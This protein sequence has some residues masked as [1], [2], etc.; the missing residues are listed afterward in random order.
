MPTNGLP[1]LNL[2]KTPPTP[3][4]PS[5]W[6]RFFCVFGQHEE[7]IHVETTWER[8]DDWKNVIAKG[9]MFILQCKH[10]GNVRSKQL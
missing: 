8:L 10:C 2:S 6:Q 1:I 7:R 3:P 5:F 9:P 4:G